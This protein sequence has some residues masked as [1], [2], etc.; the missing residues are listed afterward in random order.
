MPAKRTPLGAEQCRECCARIL[1]FLPEAG[2]SRRS[3]SR[4][5]EIRNPVVVSLSGNHLIFIIFLCENVSRVLFYGEDGG[6]G[7]LDIS[8]L[9]VSNRN[10]ICYGPARRSFKCTAFDHWT[11]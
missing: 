11:E 10:E 4:S 6:T 8:I 2:I 3:T 1:N 7:C 9:R 5:A